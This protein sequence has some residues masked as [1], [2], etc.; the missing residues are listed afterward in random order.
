MSDSDSS[1][2]GRLIQA[3][4][5]ACGVP[6]G[7]PADLPAGHVAPKRKRRGRPKFTA[8]RALQKITS[9]LATYVFVICVDGSCFVINL[10]LIVLDW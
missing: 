5:E 10:F 2:D 1:S 3:L 8:K 9:R 4:D 6:I 7:D